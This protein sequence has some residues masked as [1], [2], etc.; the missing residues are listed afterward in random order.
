MHFAFQVRFVG[1]RGD[2]YQGD[3]AIDDVTVVDYSAGCRVQPAKAMPF[4]TNFEVGLNKWTQSSAD[5]FDWKRNK[6]HTGSVG[7]GP[8]VDHTT[9]TSK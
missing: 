3:I 7:T 1:I 8:S 5:Q 9:N 4:G 2:D 6:G